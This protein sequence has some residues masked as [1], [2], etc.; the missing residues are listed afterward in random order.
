M[1]FGPSTLGAGALGAGALGAGAKTRLESSMKGFLALT[2][3]LRMCSDELLCAD[4]LHRPELT[5]RDKCDFSGYID[6]NLVGVLTAMYQ[7]GRCTVAT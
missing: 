6:I 1:C 7:L 4:H 3:G 5:G 2:R